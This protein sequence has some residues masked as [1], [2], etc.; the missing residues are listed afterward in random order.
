MKVK[1]YLPVLIIIY[2][3]EF[4][5]GENCKKTFIDKVERCNCS[6]IETGEIKA[7]INAWRIQVLDLSNNNIKKINKDDFKEFS[8]LQELYLSNNNISVIKTNTFI[9]LKSIQKIA[10]S[11]N[12][13]T[14]I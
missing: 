7:C 10:S 13:M 12:S 1:K 9:N 11:Y 14:E 2:L 3:I 8:R 6:S 5:H 4:L